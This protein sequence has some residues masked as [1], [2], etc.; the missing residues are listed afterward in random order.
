MNFKGIQQLPAKRSLKMQSAEKHLIYLYCITAVS[1][2]LKEVVKLVSNLYFVYHVDL[3]AIVGKVAE[4]EF[5]QESLAT[6]MADLEWVKT[7][8]SLHEKVIEGVMINTYVIPFKFATLFNTEESLTAMLTEYAE[9]FKTILKKLKDKE[10]WGVKVYCDTGRLKQSLVNDNSEILE[11]ENKITSSSVGTAYFLK[12]KKDELIKDA[13]NKKIN[14]CGQKSFELLKELDVEA[15]INKLLPREVTERPEDMILNSAFLVAKDKVGNF[16]DR[17][18]S[19][20]MRY[21]DKGFS[22]VCTGPWPPYNFCRLP[23]EKV[24]SG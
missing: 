3:Y 6:N 12:K 5:G 8:I 18:D 15:R 21:E 19:L 17:V 4:S 1:P 11:I 14:E 16:V 7:K 24:Q 20:K 13:L 9:K 23:K 10:E 2:V 22:I